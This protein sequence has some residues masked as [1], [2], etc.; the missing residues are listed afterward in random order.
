MTLSFTPLRGIL[1]FLLLSSFCAE[2]NGVD[3]SGGTHDYAT[4]FGKL[5]VDFDSDEVGCADP[6]GPVDAYTWRLVGYGSNLNVMMLPW[7]NAIVNGRKDLAFLMVN[8][9]WAKVQRE[10]FDQVQCLEESNG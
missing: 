4:L 10:A 5:A 1:V 7:V 9:R 3:I 8:D 2:P 6:A